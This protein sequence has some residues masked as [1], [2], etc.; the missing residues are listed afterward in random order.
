L[1]KIVQGLII[2]RE[3]KK[4]MKRNQFMGWVLIIFAVCAL[5]GL[6]FGPGNPY[7]LFID[8]FVAAIWGVSGIVMLKQKA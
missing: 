7:G 4:T 8:L 6:V 1:K 2:L 3:G 5:I